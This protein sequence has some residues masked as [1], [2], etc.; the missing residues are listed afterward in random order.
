LE[1]HEFSNVNQ[2]LQRAVAH[3]N[4]ARDARTHC[5]YRESGREKEKSSVGALDENVSNDED[6]EMCVAEWVD[7]PK[8]KPVTCP[9]LKPSPESERR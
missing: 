1:G 9:F 4:C 6:T 3:E 7:M 5:R 8:G 2:V